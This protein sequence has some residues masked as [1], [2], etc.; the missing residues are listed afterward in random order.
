MPENT[1]ELLEH[2]KSTS[3][4][5]SRVQID[6]SGLAAQVDNI[7]SSLPELTNGTK[8]IA[9]VV[10][11]ELPSLRQASSQIAD[12]FPMVNRSIL[13]LSQQVSALNKGL[14]QNFSSV[15]QSIHPMPVMLEDA[16]LAMLNGYQKHST[17][18]TVTQYRPEEV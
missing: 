17:Y 11:E 10:E 7:N 18:P 2:L 4:T 13:A 14:E 15:R 6:L 12:E 16:I 1:S 8:D 3:T 5:F 9:R